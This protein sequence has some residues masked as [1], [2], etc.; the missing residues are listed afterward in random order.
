MRRQSLLGFLVLNVVVTFI[1][2]LGII[3]AYTQ[4]VPT[5]TPRQSPPL[6]VVVTNT[7]DPNQTQIV[8]IVTATPG[9]A[10][11]TLVALNVTGNVANPA[12]LG[13]IPTLDP[14]LLP[15]VSLTLPSTSAA[16]NGASTQDASAIISP[17]D[18]SGCPTYTIKSGDTPGGIATNFNVPLADL[19]KSDHLKID[20]VLQIGQVLII[21]Q[22]NC[23][24]FTDTPAPTATSAAEPT[25]PP[26]STLAP[27]AANAAI[28]ISQVIKPGDITEEGV[29]L[30]NT[31]TAVVDLK[32]WTLSDGGNN[33]FTFPTYRMFPGGRVLINTRAGT[34]TP[35][36][37]FWGKSQ[38]LWGDPSVSITLSDDKNAVQA[39]YTLGVTPV[40]PADI[41][42]TATP[43]G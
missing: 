19:Y 39:V 43:G 18:P 4:L 23:G 3:V 36:V 38:P 9:P 2:T 42:P 13:T 40:S 33:V 15:L 25:T 1:V 34:N 16:D 11:S 37:L 5:P 24:L 27:T 7:P 28:T 29:E 30:T 6:F 8:R 41:S 10:A 35:R 14:A 17:T 20:P 21:P 32:K 26:T 12:A 31:S 22:N